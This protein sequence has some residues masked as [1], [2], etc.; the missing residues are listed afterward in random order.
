LNR[1]S[2]GVSAT[3]H[4]KANK[5]SRRRSS[6]QSGEN[7]RSLKP[8]PPSDDEPTLSEKEEQPT[9]LRIEYYEPELRDS[10]H[11]LPEDKS[12]SHGVPYVEQGKD[13]TIDRLAS[14]VSVSL[15]RVCRYQIHLLVTISNNVMWYYVYV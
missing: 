9:I 1:R 5:P 3:S 12:Q 2:C 7:D 6:L 8:K 14:R 15:S 10:E 11:L 4:E 13:V